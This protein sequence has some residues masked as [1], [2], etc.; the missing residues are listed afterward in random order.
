MPSY[1]YRCDA[2]GL[3]TETWHTMASPVPSV[4]G[5]HGPMRIVVGALGIAGMKIKNEG[6]GYQPGLA[7]RPN[8][9]EA[10]VDG[11]RALNKLVDKRKRQADRRGID[12]RVGSARDVMKDPSTEDVKPVSLA[13]VIR[14]EGGA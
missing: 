8:D 1:V 12:L 4:C 13:D 10:W 7:R 11:K 3:E 6:A 5:A 2:C 9:P 14:E